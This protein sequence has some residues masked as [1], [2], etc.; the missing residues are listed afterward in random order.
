MRRLVN[1]L[2]DNSCYLGVIWY[3]LFFACSSGTSQIPIDTLS[4]TFVHY[5]SAITF[6]TDD[7]SA[8]DFLF[9]I[10]SPFNESL[11]DSFFE[12][13]NLHLSTIAPVFTDIWAA[14]TF[15][16]NSLFPFLSPLVQNA[17][18]TIRQVKPVYTVER[19]DSI[20][21]DSGTYL[22]VLRMQ[23][24]RASIIVT[25]VT[26]SQGDYCCGRF[27]KEQNFISFYPDKTTSIQGYVPLY[28]AKPE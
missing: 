5:R 4:G 23:V 10:Q 25:P 24:F 22:R 1:L 14:R 26:F 15:Y 12:E 3:G 17:T 27:E 18:E 2:R 28:V 6:G 16:A 13:S 20:K 8:R 11:G 9:H 21:K 19:R 7:H